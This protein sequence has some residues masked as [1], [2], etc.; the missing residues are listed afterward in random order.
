MI[1]LDPY[2][3]TA[4]IF[5]SSGFQKASALASEIQEE[6]DNEEYVEV[7][8]LGVTDKMECF[9]VGL[10][11]D[12]EENP[13]DKESFLSEGQDKSVLSKKQ[14][15]EV[16]RPD[17][18]NTPLDTDFDIEKHE[19][20]P[21]VIIDEEDE[22]PQDVSKE[23]LRWHHQLGHCPYGKIVWLAKREYCPKSWL[24]VINISTLVAYLV[25]QQKGHGKQDKR[26]TMLLK[27]K[28]LPYQENVYL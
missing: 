15:H 8:K 27:L 7:L 13:D 23:F 28:K 14:D 17:S 11:S 12:D 6:D 20:A 18:L 25:R 22:P 9:D 24:I 19:Q 16:L 5:S 21:H 1:P 4:T 26:K 10:V 3:N 2:T